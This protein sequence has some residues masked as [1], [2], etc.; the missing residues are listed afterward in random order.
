MDII[1]DGKTI[2][3]TRGELIR[4]YY[5]CEHMF[6]KEYISGNLLDQYED[7][8]NYLPEMREKLKDDEFLSE[9]AW[10]YRKFL[11]D[12]YGSDLEWECF[13][14]AYDCAK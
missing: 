2:T 13:I 11:E 14:A 7:S 12:S 3:L 1:R 8:D 5:A 6:D 9:V 10:K 4:A